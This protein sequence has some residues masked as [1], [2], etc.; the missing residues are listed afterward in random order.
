MPRLGIVTDIHED[1][2]RLRQAFEILASR[3]CD[4]YVCLGDLVGFSVPYYAHFATRDAHAVLELV[5]ERCSVVVA[6]NHDDFAIRKLPEHRG[7]V[8]YPENW[9]ALPYR[10]RARRLRGRVCLYEAEELSALLDDEDCTYLRRLPEFVVRDYFGLRIM[11]SHYAYP[12]L[13]GVRV[14]KARTPEHVA[15]HLAF[16]ARHRCTVGIS[17]HDHF[18]GMRMFTGET[19]EDHGFGTLSLERT[20]TWVH[21]PAV[22]NGTHENGAMVLDT[23]TLRVEA[24]PLGSGRHQIPPWRGQWRG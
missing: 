21:G 4:E 5:R 3:G 7:G 9:Y 22:A 15:E 19:S 6:G 12:D 11:F 20:P 8:E 2:D 18:D 24:I 16:M 13:T 17:G 10:E 23:D 14:F 1:I